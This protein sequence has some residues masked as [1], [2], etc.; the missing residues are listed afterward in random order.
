MGARA[1]CGLGRELRGLVRAGPRRHPRPE[2]APPAGGVPRPP[3]GLRPP[4]LVGPRAEL[5]GGAADPRAEAAGRGGGG[6]AAVTQS[7]PAEP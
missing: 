2:G 7:P 5:P 1:R 4:P 6:R 3:R